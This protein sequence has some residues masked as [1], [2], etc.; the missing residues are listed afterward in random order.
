ML[1]VKC[2]F[3][4]I[5][6]FWF[7]FTDPLRILDFWS[8]TCILSLIYSEL[9]Y[10]KKDIRDYF[11]CIC[12]YIHYILYPKPLQVFIS[13]VVFTFMKFLLSLSQFFFFPKINVSPCIH[14]QFFS[15]DFIMSF[16]FIHLPFRFIILLS[17]KFF[18]F[19]VI[20]SLRIFTICFGIQHEN[21]W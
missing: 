13:L 1:L 14:F 6:R 20:S 21:E 5:N 8:L 18:H 4:F 11:I 12:D 15:Q 7:I 17:S 16:S 10:F 2:T 9:C 19:S 3:C